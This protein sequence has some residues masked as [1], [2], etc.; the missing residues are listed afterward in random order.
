MDGKRRSTP[1]E[2][3]PTAEE[4][5]ARAQ[6]VETGLECR[7]CGCRDFRVVYTR[8]RPGNKIMRRRACRHCGKRITTF[9]KEM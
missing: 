6:I 9:E 8:P 1:M 2:E 3:R 7:N 5:A 4:M